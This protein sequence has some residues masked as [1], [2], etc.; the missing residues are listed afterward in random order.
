MN[1][2]KNCLLGIDLGTT[3]VKA[4]IMDENGTVMASASKANSLI[5]PSANRAEQDANLWWENTANVLRL[6]T[7]KA[8]TDVVKKIRGICVS[9]QTVT[10]L[11]V[12]KKGR[13]LRNALIWMDSRSS[14]E[15]RYIID[16]IGFDKYVS[17]IGAQPNVAFL[18]NKLLWFKK[19]EPELFAKTYRIL[20]ASSY[21]NYKLTNHMTMDID[22]ALKCQC[23][24][25]NTLKW[26]DEISHVIGID[27]NNLLPQPLPIDE[28]IGT[29]TEECAAETGLISG[30]PV[31]AGA[32][33][34]M[35]SMYAIGLSK[36]GE[37]G[38]SSGTSSLVFLG[39]NKPTSPNLP[40]VA[41]P[42]SLTN[43]P[44]IF[45]A[46][47]SSTGASLKW[48]L[49]TLGQP[50]QDYASEHHM[51]V[52]EYLNQLAAES[53]AGS[54]GLIYY[55]YLLG[56]R[57]P[58]WSS[59][60][61]GMFIGLSLDTSRKDIIR[62]IFEGTAFALRH[63]ITTLQET[64]AKADCLRITGGGSR[65]RMW[66]QIKASMLRMPVYIL[67]EKSADVP[68]G[69]ILIAGHAVGI[70]PVLSESIQKLIQV[71]EIIQPVN[72][73]ADVYDQLYP[74]YTEMYKNLNLNLKHLQDTMI[75]FKR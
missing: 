74:L 14:E 70:F 73:W 37:V 50:E 68:F 40:V 61:R 44:Y 17:I 26:S 18:P 1:Q 8:G 2:I 69:D 23:L 19:N 60:A 47:L 27:F 21:I 41:K 72:E 49:D 20:Q 42:C 10:M 32:S 15:L 33:D 55:P 9:S 11:P 38:E 29:V 3:N 58:L 22:Q 62:S 5:I 48:Y 16:S 66:S 31:V 63:V 59:H 30:I 67:D 34:A 71:K 51:S 24:D 43:L 64:G 75:S 54:N 45:D 65:S 52:Y 25:I 4:I 6:V 57:A 28:I 46:P 35:A 53:T 12:D 39:H 36:L 7:S 56:E 13:C